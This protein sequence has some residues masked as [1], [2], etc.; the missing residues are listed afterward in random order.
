MLT[1]ASKTIEFGDF[2]TPA[3]LAE[4]VCN[5]L[6]RGG[7]APNAIVEPTCGT[8]S[9]LRACVDAFPAC[10]RVLGFEVNSDHVQRAQTLPRV[11]V[12]LADF[13]KKD[14]PS[15]LNALD[16]QLLVIGNPPWVTNSAV[17]S[18]SGEN[19]P[20]KSNFQNLRGFDAITGK[21]NFD[22]SEWMLLHLMTALSG[23]RA[24]IAMLC[25]TVV[26]RKVLSH[27]WKQSLEVAKAAIHSIDAERHF[28]A[29]V[30]A[31]LL[32]CHLEPGNT[33][34]ECAIHNDLAVQSSCSRIGL[35][36]DRLVADLTAF[37]DYSHLAGES[38]LKWRSGVKHDCSRV[39]ELRR[40]GHDEFENKLGE[41]VRLEST[42]LFPMLKSSELARTAP[43]PSRVMLVTQQSV[44]EDTSEIQ[45]VAPMT[46]DYLLSHEHFFDR[47]ASSIYKNRP[48]FSV[49]GVGPYSFSPWKVAISG[50]YKRLD[51]R[52]IGPFDD[53]AVVVD[54]TCYFLPCRTE[55]DAR[56]L[57]ALLNS[58][59]AK[60]FL[61][62]LA[63]WDAK[64]PITAQLL[65]NL[66]LSKL[67]DE[68]GVQLPLWIDPP[69]KHRRFTGPSLFSALDPDL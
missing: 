5:L 57:T 63:F 11:E 65:Q 43:S 62:S 20:T 13:F 67:A 50:F 9:F 66:D 15:T 30:D 18:I 8:G 52:C 35:R 14:W 45:R 29:A 3:P 32:V 46:W 49:F 31:C 42:Y 6:L 17:G 2:Q 28:G 40:T 38:P 55:R 37:D 21:S 51:F 48:R 59:S 24:V 7:V 33:S 58:R 22:I 19:L 12:R 23:R 64:R 36:G 47:R 16:G 4:Q 61:G 56:R 68:A 69:S 34:T 39:V 26:A 44:G 54:D 53:K 10:S 60:G 25:K 41:T 27:A 1:K